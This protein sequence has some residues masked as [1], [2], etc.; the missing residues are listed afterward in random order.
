MLTANGS[1]RSPQYWHG[2]LQGSLWLENV[3]REFICPF[4]ASFSIAALPEHEQ[5]PSSCYFSTALPHDIFREAHG[6]L[7]KA[8][9]VFLRNLRWPVGRWSILGQKTDKHI[10]F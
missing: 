9:R 3:R 2:E 6:S 5:L 4:S 7:F 10:M 1:D 8:D